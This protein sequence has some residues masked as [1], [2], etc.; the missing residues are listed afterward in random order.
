MTEPLDA[1]IAREYR[2]AAEQMLCSISAVEAIK[3]RPGFGQIV[4]PVRG[5]VVASPV[6]ASYDPDPD[7]FFHWYRDSAAV[8]EALRILATERP[9]ADD[10]ARDTAIGCDR[11]TAARHFADFVAFSLGLRGLDGRRL[12][13]A[14]AWRG[15]VR[16]DFARFLRSDADL[17]GAHGAAVAGE[18]R[19]N[20][21]GT[22]DISSWPRPQ[23]DGPAL[24]A[25]TVL[26]WMRSARGDRAL[27]PVLDDAAATLLRADL[28]FT[29]AHSRDPGFDIWEE[30]LGS[31]YYTL[32]VAASALD[33]GASWLEALGEA[34]ESRACR[35]DAETIRGRLDGFWLPAEGFYRSRILA[36]GERS[37]KELDISVVLAAIHADA[38][39]PRHSVRDPYILATLAQLDAL[40]IALYP[41]NR[42]RPA[43]RGP[44]LG[45]YR[46]DVYYSGGAYYFSTLG[47]AELCF[48]AAADIA[49]ADPAAAAARPYEP[50]PQHP[51]HL[52]RSLIERGE[53]YLETVRAFTPPDGDLSEQF[54]QR[55]GEPSSAKHLAW[56][57]AAFITCVAARARARPGRRSA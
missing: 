36:S 12:L 7:Y 54:D 22:L 21:D 38:P 45:R 51:P 2:H 28:A 13:A 50:L 56:S 27:D 46:G 18:T 44:A 20:P 39:G 33:E 23:Y 10:G 35:A 43:S 47:A 16:E 31:H 29:R 37:T 1:W 5:S 41:I 34:T 55:T 49:A 52:R 48:R 8:M 32:C 57:Y 11:P 4:R 26:R 15:A 53:A 42:Q 25:L 6:P 40:F 24:R 3:A 14:P 17:A 19:V 9:L 30:E